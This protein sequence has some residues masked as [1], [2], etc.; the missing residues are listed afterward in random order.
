MLIFEMLSSY[1]K[2]KCGLVLSERFN[3]YEFLKH[4]LTFGYFNKFTV[5]K[6]R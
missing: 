6:L 5:M 4:A 2:S 3:Y 1:W